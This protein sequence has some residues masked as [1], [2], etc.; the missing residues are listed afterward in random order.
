MIRPHPG[1]GRRGGR[2][3]RRPDLSRY[4][5]GCLR[6]ER[7]RTDARVI[8]QRDALGFFKREIYRLLRRKCSGQCKSKQDEERS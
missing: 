7:S 6:R 8:F 4:S 3:I 5:L 2:K 1:N